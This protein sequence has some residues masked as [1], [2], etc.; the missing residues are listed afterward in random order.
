W[1]SR[2]TSATLERLLTSCIGSSS[3]TQMFAQQAFGIAMEDVVTFIVGN[4]GEENGAGVVML[5][6][7]GK[8]AAENNLFRAGS[9][10]H[11]FNEAVDLWG[12]DG[13]VRHEASTGHL[14][15]VQG[16]DDTGEVEIDIGQVA[17]DGNRLFPF[18]VSRMAHEE[19]G[20]G[21]AF[22]DLSQQPRG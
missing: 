19:P 10:D 5:A 18:A 14:G 22:G 9:F 2:S 1:P 20:L 12:H 16:L 21:I 11:V 7:P 17:G 8:I 13:G 15:E 4:V 3:V 6:V